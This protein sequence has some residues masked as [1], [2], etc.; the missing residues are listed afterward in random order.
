MTPSQR[1]ADRSLS[2]RGLNLAEFHPDMLGTNMGIC[3][4]WEGP[5]ILS[6]KQQRGI[7]SL[8]GWEFCLGQQAMYGR[9]ALGQFIRAGSSYARKPDVM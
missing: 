5:L 4:L 9:K 3:G 2:L 7:E 8:L 6:C 1:D